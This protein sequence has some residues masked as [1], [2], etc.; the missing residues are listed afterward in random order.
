MTNSR[1]L[2]LSPL[3]LLSLFLL[4]FNDFF[5]KDYFHN[6]LTG[7]LSDF[8]GLFAFAIFWTA[9]FPR[10]KSLIFSLIVVFFTFWKSPF[11]GSFIELW[12]TSGLFLIGRT[13]D[14]TD[15]TAFLVLPLAWIYSEKSEPA[16]LPIFS[17]NFALTVIAFVSVFAFTATSQPEMIEM[18]EFSAANY[19]I[20]KPPTEVLKKLQEFD[21]REF[22]ESWNQKN[23][24]VYFTLG[25]QGEICN[26]QPSAFFQ[27]ERNRADSTQIK[28][29]SIRYPC[30][31]K[32]LNQSEKFKLMFETQVIN[33]LKN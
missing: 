9:F 24:T 25:L 10:W 6:F 14:Y 28:L 3:F 17:Q 16:L 2:L 5:L 12:N 7:K 13:I 19:T 31:E 21:T 22:N 11:S 33:F 20:E 32:I 4:L 27:I 29:D 8:A 15:L 26:G 1:K 30:K 18:E 23:G